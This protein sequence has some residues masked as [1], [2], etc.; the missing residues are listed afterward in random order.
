[1]AFGIWGAVNGLAVATGPLIGGSLTEHLSWHWI[2]WL[3]VPIGIALL[4][5]ARLRLPRATAP[6]PASTCPA[7]SLAS[8]ACSA[9]STA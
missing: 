8:P 6:T 2:F 1:M 5:L 9:S 4:P 3:N 7:P